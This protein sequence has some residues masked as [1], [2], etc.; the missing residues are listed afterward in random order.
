MSSAVS[1]SSF[2]HSW[3]ESR[4]SPLT[5]R[6]APQLY[7]SHSPHFHAVLR[8]RSD[9]QFYMDGARGPVLEGPKQW[10]WKQNSGSGSSTE[11]SASDQVVSAFGPLF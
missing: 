5:V 1:T 11:Y 9:P 6:H 4:V 8:N 10:K 7:H 3:A 2:L